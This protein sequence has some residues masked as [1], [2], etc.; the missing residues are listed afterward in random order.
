MRSTVEYQIR[1]RRPHWSPDCSTK[2]RRMYARHAVLRFLDLLEARGELSWWEI[3]TRTA[4]VSEW[5]DMQP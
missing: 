3:R 1:W 4:L 2:S 5:E